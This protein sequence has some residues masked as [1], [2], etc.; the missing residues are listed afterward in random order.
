MSRTSLRRAPA[1]LAAAASL[2]LLGACSLGSDR[3]IAE[4]HFKFAAKGKWAEACALETSGFRGG[5][6][7]KACARQRASDPGK[8]LSDLSTAGMKATDVKPT[9]GNGV[10]A[11]GSW[12]LVSFTS[13]D[14]TEYRAAQVVDDKVN[15][16]VVTTKESWEAGD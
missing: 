16:V 6:S 4:E 13:D 1:L 11:K 9:S 12:I 14:T 8:V 7:V 15:D 3:E 5:G 2:G 10:S